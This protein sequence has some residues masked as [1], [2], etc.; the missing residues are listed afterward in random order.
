ME[1]PHLAILLD[2]KSEVGALRAENL[3][4]ARSRQELREGQQAAA[5]KIEEIQKSVIPLLSSVSDMKP[6]VDTLMITHN[7][8]GGVV[9]A[10]TATWTLL[11]A[12][13]GYFTDVIKAKLHL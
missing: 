5:H 1:G 6:K 10:L 11:A 12:G 13:V 3:Q 7:R 4:A 9:L 2:I 8:L